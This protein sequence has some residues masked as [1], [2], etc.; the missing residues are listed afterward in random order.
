MKQIIFN[1]SIAAIHRTEL[2]IYCDI[3]K[4][5]SVNIRYSTKFSAL[6]LSWLDAPNNYNPSMNRLK[7]KLTARQANKL[8][9]TYIYNRLRNLA[10][11]L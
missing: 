10:T 9:L 5:Y 7:L 6:S 3:A 4:K 2:R 8:N 1:D 11:N